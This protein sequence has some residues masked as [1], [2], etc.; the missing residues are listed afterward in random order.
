[1]LV[2]V[3]VTPG[4]PPPVISVTRPL[5]AAPLAWANIAVGTISSR[6]AERKSAQLRRM[7][8]SSQRRD[9]ILV[10]T[11]SKPIGAVVTFVTRDYGQPRAERQRR[12]R[13]GGGPGVAATAAGPPPGPPQSAARFLG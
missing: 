4:S 7:R 1:M 3:T 5:R 13:E 8:T 6:S 11:I 9:E 2:A 12:L 10:A